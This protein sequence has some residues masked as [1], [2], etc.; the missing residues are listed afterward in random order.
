MDEQGYRTQGSSPF[1]Y[2]LYLHTYLTLCL[3]LLQGGI[4]MS[5]LQE[6]FE[7]LCRT[8]LDFQD[9]Q[10]RATENNVKLHWAQQGLTTILGIQSMIDEYPYLKEIDI[11]KNR[12]QNMGE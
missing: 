10:D 3:L 5:V 8:Y 2:R 11:Y 9:K 4:T 1:T 7:E 6:S 12:I